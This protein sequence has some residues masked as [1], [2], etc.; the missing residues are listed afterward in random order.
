MLASTESPFV[1]QPRDPDTTGGGKRPYSCAFDLT[2]DG[3]TTVL[4]PW[5]LLCNDFSLER[6]RLV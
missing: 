1:R 3:L 6:R 5:D 2:I 4:F